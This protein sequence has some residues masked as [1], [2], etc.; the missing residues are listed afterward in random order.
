[1]LDALK[2][3]DVVL[4]H[5]Y[6]D[7]DAR[8]LEV[9]LGCFLENHLVQ[10]EIGNR[11]TKSGVLCLQFLE[12]FHLIDPHAAIFFPPAVVGHL[13]D[14]KLSDNLRNLHPLCQQDFSFS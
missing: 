12:P 3:R 8:G 13:V 14:A 5:Q 9:S 10:C 2:P 4:R 1:M 6:N 7:G 11:P